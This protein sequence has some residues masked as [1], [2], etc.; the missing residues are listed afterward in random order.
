MYGPA[1]GLL[2]FLVRAALLALL[3]LGTEV[4][5]VEAQAGT[6]AASGLARGGRTA[7]ARPVAGRYLPAEWR[8]GAGG[9]SEGRVISHGSHGSGRS[10]GRGG[11]GLFHGLVL[12]DLVAALDELLWLL[13]C[14]WI[15]HIPD[16]AR[17]LAEKEDSLYLLHC[18]RLQGGEVVPHDEGP[19]V[20]AHWVVQPLTCHLG[21]AEAVG[22]PAAPGTGRGRR[23]GAGIP[24]IPDVI[25]AVDLPAV[26]GIPADLGHSTI[27]GVPADPVVLA[28]PMV[29]L[30]L[31]AW[32]LCCC[33]CSYCCC[34]VPAVADVPVVAVPA[35]SAAAVFPIIAGVLLMWPLCCCRRPC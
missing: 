8:G 26:A 2:V 6:A 3:G 21:D 30:L 27:A 5:V 17:Q 34:W 10:D 23:R 32:R 28:D 19:G 7:A 24:S 29:S 9:I 25:T 33:F 1:A 11:G 35:V 31:L 20:A 18:G 14:P 13:E 15:D 4:G 12:Q 16:V 22:C